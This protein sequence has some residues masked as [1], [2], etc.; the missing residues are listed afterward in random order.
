LGGQ[1][2]WWRNANSLRALAGTSEKLPAPERAAAAQSELTPS[3]FASHSARSA[4]SALRV[5][6]PLVECHA[7]T[8]PSEGPAAAADPSP[9]EGEMS[10]AEYRRLPLPET[11]RDMLAL[12]F[13]ATE[14][15]KSRST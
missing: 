14:V 15:E 4:S 5:R 8:A 6:A 2:S 13:T 10:E 12:V 7:W 3:Q 1:L 9:L 11:G